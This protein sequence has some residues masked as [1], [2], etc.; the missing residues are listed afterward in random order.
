MRRVRTV[1]TVVIALAVLAGLATPVV[2]LGPAADPSVQRSSGPVD[3]VWRLARSIYSES[4]DV[5][6]WLSAG[7]A[8]GDSPA[9]V[10]S[11]FDAGAPAPA[12]GN[13]GPIEDTAPNSPE[14]G[15]RFGEPQ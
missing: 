5:F 7:T 6:G 8:R 12:G 14:E 3:D 2:A 10:T 11:I 9:G 1:A 15:T 13:G 4:L